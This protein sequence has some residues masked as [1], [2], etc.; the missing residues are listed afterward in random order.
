MT[1]NAENIEDY[2]AQV[3]E[4]RRGAIEKVLAVFRENI[5]VGFTEMIQYNM[6]AFSVSLEDYPSGY[7][8]TP[9]TPLPFL[10]VANQKNSINVYYMGMYMKPAIL[11]WFRSE[12]PTHS[13]KRLDMG[14]SCIR[15]KKP[16]DIPYE[17]LGELVS[18]MSREEYIAIYEHN[19]KRGK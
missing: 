14:K 10:S 6:P 8:C 13:K 2:L 18:K 15:F 1:I 9:D 12:F 4:E 16:E 11:E 3:P 7:H 19:L 17:L 5:P